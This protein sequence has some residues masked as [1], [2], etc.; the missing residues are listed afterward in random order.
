[1]VSIFNVSEL[2]ITTIFGFILGFVICIPIGPINLFSIKLTTAHRRKEALY[3]A[4]GGS[5]MDFLYFFILMNGVSFFEF[6][7]LVTTIFKSLGILFILIMGIKEILAYY[8]NKKI[9]NDEVIGEREKQKFLE[10]KKTSGNYLKAFMTG[11]LIYT[12]NPTLIASMSGL[13]AFVKSTN[14]FNFNLITIF[15]FS[16]FAA[17][18][19]FSWFFLLTRVVKKN[20]HRFSEKVLSRLNLSFGVLMVI[21]AIVMATKLLFIKVN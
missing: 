10:L 7:S 15:S 12:S 2:L 5:V 11:V 1:M 18:G 21:V 3:L 9:I 20:L 6:G 13:S 16:L 14:F 8:Q 19:T 17:I 4:L